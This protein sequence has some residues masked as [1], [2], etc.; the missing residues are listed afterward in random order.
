MRGFDGAQ[1]LASWAAS[2][3]GASLRCVLSQ[4]AGDAQRGRDRTA[5]LAALGRFRCLRSVDGL[6]CVLLDDVMT[7]GA[8]LEDCAAT[9]RTSG[10]I[11]DHAIVVA[12]REHESS[13]ERDR[14]R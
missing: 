11:V 2:R 5:R 14:H 3:S 7:T 10:A 12:V 13:L 1:L 6:R 8:T 4:I 9:L